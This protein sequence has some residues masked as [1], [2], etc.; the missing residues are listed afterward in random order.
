VCERGD[1]VLVDLPVEIDRCL[2]D[3][4]RALN[5]AGIRT[6]YCCCGHH[7]DRCGIVSL[8]DGRS[9]AIGDHESVEDARMLM[10]SMD[11]LEPGHEGRVEIRNFEARIVRRDD[12]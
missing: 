10:A 5:D 7:H 4:V 9:I 6:R 12:G 8:A 1:R 2:E 3:I 11:R